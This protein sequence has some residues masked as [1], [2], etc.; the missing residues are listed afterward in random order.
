LSALTAGQVPER[1][2]PW[3]FL[4]FKALEVGVKPEA[5]VAGLIKEENDAD[6]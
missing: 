1:G 5:M 4:R 2:R 3:P 6:D